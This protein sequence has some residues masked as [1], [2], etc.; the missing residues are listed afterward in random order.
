VQTARAFT[1]HDSDQLPPLSPAT[2]GTH[3]QPAAARSPVLFRSLMN[4][5]EGGLEAVG[6]EAAVSSCLRCVMVIWEISAVS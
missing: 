4:L 5:N 1:D 6:G 3:T 2:L